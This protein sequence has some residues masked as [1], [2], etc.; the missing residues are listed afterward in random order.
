MCT[1]VDTDVLIDASRRINDALFS[2]D[3]AQQ[4]GSLAVSVMTAME[5]LGGCRNKAESVKVEMML[6]DLL[7]IPFTAPI[8]ALALNLLRQY[9]LSHGLG[10]ADA[11]IAATSL[12]YALPL[13]TKNQRDYRFMQDIDLLP[14]PHT[15]TP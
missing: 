2:L 5:L 3:T 15:A 11:L 8:S 1:L 12:H 9:R 7:V 6:S 10:N 13:L 14:Y 4:Q